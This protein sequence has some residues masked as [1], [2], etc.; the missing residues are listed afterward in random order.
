MHFPES[1]QISTE[2]IK[3]LF[4][5][6]FK[7]HEEKIKKFNEENFRKQEENLKKLIPE[8]TTPTIKCLDALRKR[9]TVVKESLKCTQSGFEGKIV[10]FNERLTAAEKKNQICKESDVKVIQSAKPSWVID[11]ENKL[12]N[13][14]D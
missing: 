2:Q 13:L 4:E 8:N 5:Q 7:S 14:E 11:I 3:T 6:M 1:V 9:V 10:D 12:V